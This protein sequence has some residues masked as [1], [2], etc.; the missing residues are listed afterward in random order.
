MENLKAFKINLQLFGDEEDFT[1]DDLDVV[2]SDAEVEDFEDD[3]EQDFQDD[4]LE[5]E[6][7]EDDEEVADPQESTKQSPE[8]N[9]RMKK[10]RLKAEADAMKKF[11]AERN[12]LMKLKQEIEAEKKERE[13]KAEYLTDE[14]IWQKADEEGVSESVA[15]RLLEVEFK[16]KLEDEKRKT[17]E[18]IE[19]VENE[20]RQLMKDEFY[21]DIAPEME[22]ILVQRPDLNPST[23]Y[24]HLKGQM[25]NELFKKASKNVEKRTIANVQDGMR[26]RNVPSS[27]GDSSDTLSH[28]S[29][30]GHEMANAFGVD[31]REVAK[32]VKQNKKKK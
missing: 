19:Q 1:N 4:D 2:D 9:A 6:E 24:Y 17:R 15:K 31:P 7:S 14:K 16:E 12:E 11:E 21:H 28:L 30:E 25:A 10:M 3:A 26:R 8:E 22:K 5:D 32:Y 27:S 20:K 13:L 18:R 29:K 23:V